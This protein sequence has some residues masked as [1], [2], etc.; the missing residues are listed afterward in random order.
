[1]TKILTGDGQSGWKVS[2]LLPSINGG[3]MLP[4]INEKPLP[5][6][7]TLATYN[8]LNKKTIITTFNL[9]NKKNISNSFTQIQQEQT[10]VSSAALENNKNENNKFESEKKKKK[11]QQQQQQQRQSPPSQKQLDM[12]RSSRNSS[13]TETSE[14]EREEA[15]KNKVT[16][17]LTSIK[18]ENNKRSIKAEH[19][20]SSSSTNNNENQEKDNFEK[21]NDKSKEKPTKMIKVDKEKFLKEKPLIKADSNQQLFKLNEMPKETQI[22]IK[23]GDPISPQQQQRQQHQPAMTTIIKSN[24]KDKIKRS[25]SESNI[26]SNEVLDDPDATPSNKLFKSKST[27]NIKS[28]K[29]LQEIIKNRNT[30]R[31]YN[32]MPSHSMPPLHITNQAE[33][34][35]NFLEAKIPPVLKFKADQRT[36][37]NLIIKHSK[38]NYE[39]F[40]RAKNILDLIR[41]KYSGGVVS[42][43][44]ANFGKRIKSKECIELIGKYLEEN[45][46]TGEMTINFA[47]G[48]TC[49]GRI[50]SYNIIKNKPEA[51]KFG[52]E[53]DFLLNFCLSINKL[54]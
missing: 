21:D 23:E 39:H 44:E 1:M 34:K 29:I 5:K 8:A 50:V 18:L 43:Y 48:L 33:V 2:S 45:K 42:Y 27:R 10:V 49:S 52:M 13:N 19:D 51:R 7:T 4:S 22:Q 16:V 38:T 37:Q 54:I 40:F 20:N 31:M 15:E 26:N 9:S 17:I 36:V 32:S 24:K 3:A 6:S 25:S 41:S 12:S 11:Q 46:I 30:I 35:K 28:G 53:K 47:P 14:L